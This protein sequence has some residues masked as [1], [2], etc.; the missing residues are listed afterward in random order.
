MC[1]KHNDKVGSNLPVA[2]LHQAGI[3]RHCAAACA[4]LTADSADPGRSTLVEPLARE[5]KEKDPVMG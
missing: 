1:I 4:L 2:C 5:G 3:A